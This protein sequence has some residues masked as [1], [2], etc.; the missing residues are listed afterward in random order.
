MLQLFRPAG[1]C[2]TCDTPTFPYHPHD[3]HAHR[4][5]VKAASASTFQPRGVLLAIEWLMQVALRVGNA[6]GQ[7]GL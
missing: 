2:C 1:G 7:Q 4:V 5:G 6:P 3:L